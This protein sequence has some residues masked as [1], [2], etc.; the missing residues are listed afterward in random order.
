MLNIVTADLVSG[1]V[2]LVE[3][4]KEVKT[5]AQVS[6]VMRRDWMEREDH[7]EIL[8]SKP[9]KGGKW[10]TPVLVVPMDGEV[11]DVFGQFITDEPIH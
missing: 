2:S 11:S 4:H 1:T 8:E 3:S 5:L 9:V 6:K 7:L 10:V